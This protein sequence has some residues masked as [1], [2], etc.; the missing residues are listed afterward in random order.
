V[1]TGSVYPVSD[2]KELAMPEK[3]FPEYHSHLRDLLGK[4]GKELPGPMGGFAQLHKQALTEGA[5]TAKAKGLG[6]KKLS[7]PRLF[8]MDV[9]EPL[10]EAG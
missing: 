8:T 6:K 5:L 3:R 9:Q 2:R 7:Q 4:L 1:A 10:A